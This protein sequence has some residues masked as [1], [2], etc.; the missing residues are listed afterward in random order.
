[1]TGFKVFFPTSTV[2][3]FFFSEKRI[4]ELVEKETLSMSGDGGAQVNWKER[5]AQLKKINAE[6]EIER[7]KLA[8]VRLQLEV[9]LQELC[10]S[11]PSAVKP[12]SL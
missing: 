9:R 2:C 4:K 7:A 12:T 8:Q 6:L 3:T 10:P 11:T 1:M 5:C